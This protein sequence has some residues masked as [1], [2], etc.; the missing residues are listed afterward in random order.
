MGKKEQKV[1]NK[2]LPHV[3]RDGIVMP[4]HPIGDLLMN[5]TGGHPIH[6]ERLPKAKRFK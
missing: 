2:P 6:P 5:T 4:H 1:Q 3:E